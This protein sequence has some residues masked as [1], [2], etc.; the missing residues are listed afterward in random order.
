MTVFQYR[1][2]NQGELIV[3]ET[4]DEQVDFGNVQPEF[5]DEGFDNVDLE[6]NEN[7]VPEDVNE[8]FF[9]LLIELKENEN[10]ELIEGIMYDIRHFLGTSGHLLNP[11]Y[12]DFI[13]AE[14]HGQDN[15]DFFSM[16]FNLDI[17]DSTFESWIEILMNLL[18]Q[19]AMENIREGIE[20]DRIFY[21]DKILTYCH[22]TPFFNAAVRALTENVFS[23]EVL[24]YYFDNSNNIEPLET[25]MLPEVLTAIR[26]VRIDVSTIMKLRDH[27]IYGADISAG[28]IMVER[29]L[30]E[31][32]QAYLA[33]EDG[34]VAMFRRIVNAAWPSNCSFHR[35]FQDPEYFRLITSKQLRDLQEQFNHPLTELMAM[36]KSEL[37]S[38]V[39]QQQVAAVME[40][41]GPS[42]SSSEPLATTAVSTVVTTHQEDTAAVVVVA[43]R[44][45]KRVLEEL[46][47]N[48]VAPLPSPKSRRSRE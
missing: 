8:E 20:F 5:V 26:N 21:L 37:R 22:D 13:Y 24:K 11:T 31:E 2:I 46:D 36:S 32:N 44:A 41:I 28:D 1:S 40:N 47:Q 38:F 10:P 14:R 30:S 43:P 29:L 25:L 23:F 15:A 4:A 34:S 35:K 42:S 27:F 6:N 19:D 17:D 7:A 18:I 3:S 33:S 45:A 16:I 48:T 39:N 9:N 12:I